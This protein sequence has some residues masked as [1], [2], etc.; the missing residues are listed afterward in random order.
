VY[1]IPGGPNVNGHN[2]RWY[3]P[4]ANHITNNKS[5]VNH[6]DQFAQDWVGNVHETVFETNMLVV[7]DHNVIAIA[8]DPKLF[9]WLETQGINVTLCDFRCRGFWDGGLHCLTVDV[10]RDGGPEDYFPN[11]PDRP[12]LDWL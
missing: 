7:D 5:F 9:R 10:I 6:I 8:E 12:Y 1:H 4:Q 3:V 11:R 2:G